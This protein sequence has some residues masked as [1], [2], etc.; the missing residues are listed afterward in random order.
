MDHR[1]HALRSRIWARLSLPLL[2]P[3]NDTGHIPASLIQA[4]K[5]LASFRVFNFSRSLT[6]AQVAAVV[7]V[8]ELHPQLDDAPDA[9]GDQAHAADTGH[10]LRK[11]RHVVCALSS[12]PGRLF[13]R[14]PGRPSPGR[15]TMRA[16]ILLY[17][18]NLTR[19][20]SK[21]YPGLGWGRTEHRHARIFTFHP[22]D[23][24]GKI[25][26]HMWTRS[27]ARISTTLHATVL[28][29]AAQNISDS[30]LIQLLHSWY[31][32]Q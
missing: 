20:P 15:A 12:I 29:S 27:S 3:V 1:R 19:T 32:P 9:D 25:L 7:V 26:P 4:G 10:D 31:A 2:L 11:I 16:L 21:Y 13:R 28:A 17:I 23:E 30:S 8:P 6:L 14:I 22:Q 18:S 5:T 24:R